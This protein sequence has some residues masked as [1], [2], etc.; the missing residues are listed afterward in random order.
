MIRPSFEQ[1]VL[2]GQFG[3]TT[4]LVIVFFFRVAADDVVGLLLSVVDTES[5]EAF[6]PLSHALPTRGL[7]D[8]AHIGRHACP[9]IPIILQGWQFEPRIIP[10][11]VAVSQ[12]MLLQLLGATLHLREVAMEC[13]SIVI[14]EVIIPLLGLAVIETVVEVA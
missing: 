5:L 6:L 11:R 8:V 13:H 2:Q 10:L 4:Q 14:R 12:R 7:I 3:E 1:L 9:L